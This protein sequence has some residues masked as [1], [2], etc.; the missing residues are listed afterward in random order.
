MKICFV[1]FST[2][3]Y[4]VAT[5]TLRPL[6]GSQSAMCYLAVA[7]ARLGHEVTAVTGTSEP[8]F[9]DGVECINRFIPRADAVIAL[10]APAHG[11]R[12]RGCLHASTRLILWT[13]HAANQPGMRNLKARHVREAWDHIVCV[14]DWQRRGIMDELGVEPGRASVLRNAVSPA[15]EGMFTSEDEFLEAKSARPLRRAYTS[16]PYRGLHLLLD[17]TGG[18]A[19]LEVY[20]SMDVYMG[21][22][23]RKFAGLYERLKSTDGI[24]Y[25]GSLPQSVLAE[26]LKR[27]HVLSYPN[28]FP[29]T[30]CIAVMEA[31]A[32]GLQVITSDLGALPETT[33]GFA[34]LVPIDVDIDLDRAIIT[35]KDQAAYVAAFSEALSVPYSSSNLY[36]QVEHMNRHHTWAIRARQW[37][38]MLS[39]SVPP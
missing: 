4:N 11:V 39:G 18:D 16:T 27:A 14:S 34:R 33:E 8:G 23:D 30:S 35:V 1:D 25:V 31:M 17:V 29:E 37:T 36:A 22:D 32:A 6:G 9:I 10:N 26:R 3:D 20:S 24:D 15:F 28:I 7:L 2:W 5:P 38:E 12:L 21:Q 13:Q 19:V